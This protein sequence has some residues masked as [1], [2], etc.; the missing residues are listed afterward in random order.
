[1]KTKHFICQ[2]LQRHENSTEIGEGDHDINSRLAEAATT[3][4]ETHE[5][6]TETDTENEGDGGESE[7]YRHA[8]ATG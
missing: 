4:A 7:Q 1:M 3:I 5:A 8:R 6:D 2:Y